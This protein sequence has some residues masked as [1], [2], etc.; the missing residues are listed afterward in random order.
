MTVNHAEA[1]YQAFHKAF[2][3][4][5]TIQPTWEKTPE[6]IRE[7]WQAVAD[8]AEEIYVK[9]VPRTRKTAAKVV[10]TDGDDSSQ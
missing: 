6:S 9:P 1:L 3:G 4:D 7:V 2:Y 8:K 10:T 5:L